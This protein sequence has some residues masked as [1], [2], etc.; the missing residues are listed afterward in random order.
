MYIGTA[1]GGAVFPWTRKDVYNTAAIAK[2]KVAGVPLITICGVIAAAFS[3]WML[4]YYLTV[5]ALGFGGGN[6]TGELLMLAIFVGWS[7]YF[8]IRRWWLK[9]VG[10]DLDLAY[11]EVPPI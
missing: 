1:L 11:K 4:Y 8:F 6:L 9:R 7:A 10:I 5:P 3:A 2:Y